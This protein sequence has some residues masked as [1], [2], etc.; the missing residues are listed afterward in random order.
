MKKLGLY[1][2]AAILRTHLS[3]LIIP[4]LSTLLTSLPPNGLASLETIYLGL[5]PYLL[6]NSTADLRGKQ[7]GQLASCRISDLSHLTLKILTHSLPQAGRLDI[8]ECKSELYSPLATALSFLDSVWVSSP[9][10]AFFALVI[11]ALVF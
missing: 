2:N 8:A 4:T 11:A 9:A 10:M 5:S 1:L 6:T 3:A 7:T